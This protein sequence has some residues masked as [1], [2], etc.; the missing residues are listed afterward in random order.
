MRME[1]CSGEI[2]KAKE[3]VKNAEVSGAAAEVAAPV[4]AQQR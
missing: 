3:K 4:P 2:D 1:L